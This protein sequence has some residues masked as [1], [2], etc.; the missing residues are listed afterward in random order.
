M[1]VAFQAARV[2]LWVGLA[3]AVALLIPL[4]FP[5]HIGLGS[6]AL[7]AL[8]ALTLFGASEWI[9]ESVRKPYV[10]YGYMYG[11]GMR[12][13]EAQQIK[14]GGGIL[15]GALWVRHKTPD[16]NVA[17]GEDVFRVACRS[18]HTLDGYRGLREPLRGLDEGYVYEL[19]GRL[20]FLRGAMPPFAGTDSERW[21]L[22]KYLVSKAGA[23]WSMISGE[24][25]FD[26]RCG[27]CHSRDR[28]RPLY[29][30]LN[31][32]SRQDLLDLLPTLGDMAE[33]MAPWSGSDE[34]AGMLA[35]F[36]LA[37]YEAEPAGDAASQ[38]GN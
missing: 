5:K 31:G 9:R 20:E 3:F 1:P 15:A 12:V 27:F 8:A 37:W 35:D 10:I 14:Y 22:A 7:F 19:T 17:V 34:E 33:G 11:N 25:V 18:C 23:E 16:P 29:D 28:F 4:I 13:T 32:N 30:G 36:L 6:A 2:L 38:G 21:A 24:E 26:K